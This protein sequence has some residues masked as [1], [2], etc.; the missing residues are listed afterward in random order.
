MYNF[1][2]PAELMSLS[3]LPLWALVIGL[4]IFP[5]TNAFIEEMTYNGYVFPRL[6][7]ALRSAPLT[8]VLV[9]FVFSVQHVAIPFAF[10]AK[11]LLWRILSFIPLL[12]FWV[13]VYA[14][15]RR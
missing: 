7:S 11:F 13:L 6:E 10:D 8:I 15:V 14:K 5:L 2:P 9:T 3:K 1:K 12:L 4:G